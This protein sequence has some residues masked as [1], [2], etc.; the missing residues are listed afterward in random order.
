MSGSHNGVT[1]VWVEPWW[2][3]YSPIDYEAQLVIYKPSSLSCPHI[4][5]QSTYYP[6]SLPV[7]HV[8]SHWDEATCFLEGVPCHWLVTQDE[9]DEA[10]V[11]WV[12]CILLEIPST[13]KNSLQVPGARFSTWC[14]P[15][16]FCSRRD[17]SSL[18]NSSHT[19]DL[20][21]NCG[22]LLHLHVQKG[23][24]SF[25]MSKMQVTRLTLTGNLSFFYHSKTFRF[26]WNMTLIL[27]SMK[28]R[29]QVVVRKSTKLPCLDPQSC[30]DP[31]WDLFL[32]PILTSRIESYSRNV[33]TIWIQA[34]GYIPGTSC[35]WILLLY[36]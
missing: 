7:K 27:S 3:Y 16:W 1:S 33:G 14:S 25:S 24:Q 10:S 11:V 9:T 29:I 32:A 35:L 6:W 31:S 28:M 12:R 34:M 36:M 18:L 20:K 19:R 23:Q 21:E 13:T 4:L 30:L 22:S 8:L 26:S 2:S 5:R 17:F 15:K